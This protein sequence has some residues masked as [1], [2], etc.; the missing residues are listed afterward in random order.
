MI[1]TLAN[2]YQRWF[3]YEK[4]SHRQVLA[5]LHTVPADRRAADLFHKAIDLMGHLI[6]VRRAW[7][8]RLGASTKR[9]ADLFPSAVALVDLPD[10]LEA[11]ER[12]WS[13]YLKN[14]DEQEL[15]R[16]K[17]FT[18]ASTAAGLETGSLTSSPSC[19][20]TRCTTA[21]RLHQS[22]EQSVVY[23]PRLTSYSGVE[24]Q[25]LAQIRNP[26]R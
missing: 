4:E 14:L 2:Q 20:D 10:E 7:L 6:A 16:A 23:R 17:S 26:R 25:A 19:T 13:D 22:F 24:S 8:H 5:S 21:A 15:Q 9:P 11:M 1:P 12:D 18:R 3:E